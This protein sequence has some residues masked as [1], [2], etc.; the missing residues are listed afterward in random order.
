MLEDDEYMSD[1]TEEDEDQ[2]QQQTQSPSKRA[3]TRSGKGE[4]TG[5]RI[6][7]ALPAP[8]PTSYNAQHLYGQCTV[9]CFVVFCVLTLH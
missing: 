5:Y 7:G 6:Q 1:L 8:R 3:K 2:A 4:A 9:S